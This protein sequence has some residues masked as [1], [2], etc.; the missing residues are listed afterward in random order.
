MKTMNKMKTVILA[1]LTLS[2]MANAYTLEEIAGSYRITSSQIPGVVNLVSLKANGD[3]TLKEISDRGTI[4]CKG[5][6][7]YADNL[8]RSIVKCA[9]PTV[10]YRQQIDLGA[11][12][13]LKKFQAP[14]S[15]DLF[16]MTFMMD[17][18]KVPTP[19]NAI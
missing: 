19:T 11:V 9:D 16:G 17:F 3:I 15:S 5:Q 12:R 4:V 18:V 13:N 8:L 7:K 2:P 14:V 6:S 1:V 10:L